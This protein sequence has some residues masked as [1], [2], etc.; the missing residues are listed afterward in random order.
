MGR[1]LVDDL[2]TLVN[3]VDAPFI[4][5]AD[6]R[7]PARIE[8]I[9]RAIEGKP[10]GPAI[11]ALRIVRVDAPATAAD[12]RVLVDQHI[13]IAFDA[14]LDA[15]PNWAP[16]PNRLC[17]SMPKPLVFSPPVRAKCTSGLSVQVSW[18]TTSMSTRPSR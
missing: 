16:V 10:L 6:S 11:A 5:Q 7:G 8:R 1:E 4:A 2:A 14:R 18:V 17:S 15:N 9:E 3:R 12:V 13:R